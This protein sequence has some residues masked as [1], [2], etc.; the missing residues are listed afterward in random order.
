MPKYLETYINVI[1]EDPLLVFTWEGEDWIPKDKPAGII[2]CFPW[3]AEDLPKYKERIQSHLEEAPLHRIICMCHTREMQRYME[4]LETVLCSPQGFVDPQ[5]FYVRP[6]DKIADAVYS[7]RSSWY[8][9]LYLLDGV[10]IPWIWLTFPSDIPF[11]EVINS[12][13][14]I[15]TPQIEN[16]KFRVF[17]E[18]EMAAWVSKANV[19]LALSKTEGWM[20]ALAEYGLSGL[21]LVTTR[22][23]GHHFL[24]GNGREAFFPRKYTINVEPNSE[25]VV[26]AIQWWKKSQPDPWDI[27]KRVLDTVK[28]YYWEFQKTLGVLAQGMGG[29]VGPIKRIRGMAYYAH[30][31][32][33]KQKFKHWNFT[34]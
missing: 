4:P 24:G 14:G 33:F 22:S 3:I 27:R 28:E 23:E 34:D 25:E 2:K 8:K 15:I 30:W 21:P 26:S 29:S 7:A 18:E 13:S 9:R 16:S 17:S 11:E 32:K 20:Y 6:E 19:G 1:Q 10:K 12:S 5:V 31:E